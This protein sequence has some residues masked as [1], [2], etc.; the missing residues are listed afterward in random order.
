MAELLVGA[1]C[2]QVYLG[3]LKKMLEHLPKNIDDSY[4]KTMECIE[5]SGK[6]QH[7]LALVVL[8]W[9]ACSRRQ[10]SVVELQHAI[11]ATRYQTPLEDYIVALSDITSACAGLITIQNNKVLLVRK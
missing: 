10:L 2:E 3:D 8:M 11:A 4:F 5:A 6:Q 9:I 1:L 7:D